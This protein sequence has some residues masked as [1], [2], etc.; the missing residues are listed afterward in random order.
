M[1]RTPIDEAISALKVAP[2]QTVGACASSVAALC[3]FLNDSQWWRIMA[4]VAVLFTGLLWMA[5][6]GIIEVASKRAKARH[7]YPY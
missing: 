4:M 2:I 5:T 7:P 3:L 1:K 6:P